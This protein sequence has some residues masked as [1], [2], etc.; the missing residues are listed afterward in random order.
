VTDYTCDHDPYPDPEPQIHRELGE[1]LSDAMEDVHGAHEAWGTGERHIKHL[2]SR[3]TYKVSGAA[4]PFPKPDFQPGPE[5]NPNPEPRGFVQIAIL[6]P[7][8]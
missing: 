3:P 1:L 2:R 7:A 8:R 4:I 6:R 5:P